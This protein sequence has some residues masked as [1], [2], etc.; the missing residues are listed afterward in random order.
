M[1]F[2]SDLPVSNSGDLNIFNKR[3]LSFNKHETQRNV[4]LLIQL[5]RI[6]FVS[7]ASLSPGSQTQRR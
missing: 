7:K 5:T 1:A 3:I 4:S 2:E 6:K